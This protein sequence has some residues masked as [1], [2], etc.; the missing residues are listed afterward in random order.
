MVKCTMDHMQIKGH[1]SVLVKF[2][3]KN[4]AGW[5]EPLG[6]SLPLSALKKRRTD[7]TKPPYSFKDHGW[8][9]SSLVLALYNLL[10]VTVLLGLMPPLCLILWTHFCVPSCHC[11]GSATLPLLLGESLSHRTFKASYSCQFL[12]CLHY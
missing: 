5:I 7:S 4:R 10:I 2:I 1:R 11:H 8:W 6:C 12:T 3:Y 9:G